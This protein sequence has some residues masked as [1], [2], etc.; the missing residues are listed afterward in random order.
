MDTKNLKIMA[1]QIRQDIIDIAY[2]A[3]GPSHPGPALSCTDIVTALY[4][5][6]MKVDPN[7]PK[8]EDRDRLVLSKGHACPV[9]YSSLARKGFFPVEDLSTVRRINSKLQ[10]HPDMKKTPGVDMTSG[11][12]GNGLSAAMG[13]ALYSKTMKKGFKAFAIL[14]DGE[15]QEGPVWEAALSAA[16]FKLDNLIA[17]VD[18]NHF[19][20]CGSVEDIL[21]MA[22]L[23]DKWKSFGWNTI[24]ING[25]DMDEIVNK[26]EVA[27]NFAGAPTVIIANT[28]KGKGVSFMEHDNSW[29]QK[30]PTTDQYEQA[31]LELHQEMAK[32]KEDSYVYS[33]R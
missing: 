22:P 29:H 17:I 4:F 28:V 23:A 9:L 2:K 26:L 14:G 24:S 10:G 20:S 30:V 25:H 11:S 12:L 27:T 19:Q 15:I 21:P 6:I 32:L 1:N 7:N 16:R 3:Q 31:M 33:V 8:W 5:K 13:M 18:Y